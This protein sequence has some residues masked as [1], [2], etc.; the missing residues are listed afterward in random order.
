MRCQIVTTVIPA[1]GENFF[2][3]P[4]DKRLDLYYCITVL[5]A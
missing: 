4:L 5:I 2:A 3:V 1:V